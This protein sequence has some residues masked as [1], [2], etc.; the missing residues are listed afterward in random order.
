M[1]KLVILQ[2]DGDFS[3]GYKVTLE[4]GD[5]GERPD[6]RKRGELPPAL[7]VVRS[8]QEWR[9][10]YGSKH[11]QSRIKV[12]AV[13]NFQTVEYKQQCEEYSEKLLSLFHTWL[14][15]ESFN[16]ISN[17]LSDFNTNKEQ[18]LRIILSCDRLELRKL[19]WH[20]WNL[21]SGAEVALSAPDAARG[22]RILRENIRILII[23]GDSTGI[24]VKADEMLLQKYCRDAEI[25]TLV[26]PSRENLNSYLQDEIGWDILFFSG[27]SQTHNFTDTSEEGAVQGRIFVN[28]NDSLTMAQLRDSLQTAIQQRLQLAIFNSCDGLGIAAEL[29]SLQIPQVIVMREP[30]PDLVAQEFLKY[31]LEAF[32]N[33]R[34][35][36]NSVGY[37]RRQLAL[38]EDDFPCASW[39]PV[40]V[41]NQLEMPPTWQSLGITRSPYRGLMAFRE[42]DADNFFGREA[43]IE[44]LV[45]DVNRKPLVAV[46]GASGS[47][48]SSVVFAGLIP[49]LRRDDNRQWRIISFR[50]GKNPFESLAVALMGSCEIGENRRCQELELEV[51]LKQ[52]ISALA[53]MIADISGDGSR[54][55]LVV[56]QFEEIYT[57]C[58]KVEERQI[59]ID[60]LLNVCTGE[61][62]KQEGKQPFPLTVTVVMT[63]RADFLG[64]AMSYQPL[65]KAL[66]D[67]PPSLLV[68]MSRA[69]LE[70]A[71]IQPAARFSVELE[72]GLVNKLIDDVG[73]GEGSLPLQQFA[74]TQLWGKQRPGLLTHQAYTEI[75]GVT[76]AVAN[77]AEAVYAGLSEEQ[78]KRAQR[79]FIQLVQ[80]GEGTEDTR[81]L[82]T[83]DEVGD[84]WDLVTLLAN[85]RLLVTNRNQLVEDTVEVVHEALIR[86][87]GRLRGWMDDNREFRVWQERLKVALQQWVDSNKDDGSLLRGATLAVAEYWL[88][89]RGEE[90]S[91]PQRW[92]IEKSVE[93]RER[94]RKQKEKLRRQVIGGLAA[95]LVLALSLAGFAV[96]QWQEARIRGMNS[97]VLSIEALL[98]SKQD[99]DA[100]I[101]AVRIGKDL[102]KNPLGVPED[103]KIR[104]VVTLQK[105][106]YG[107]RELNRKPP[108]VESNDATE[109]KL[110]ELPP[111]TTIPSKPFDYTAKD[112]NSEID[113]YGFDDGKIQIVKK[114][115]QIVK[116]INRTSFRIE[117][118]KLSPNGSNFISFDKSVIIKLWSIDGKEIESFGEL[119]GH[120]YNYNTFDGW[121]T[122][123]EFPVITDVNFSPDSKMIVSSGRDGKIL[124]WN[125]ETSEPQIIKNHLPAVQSVEFSADGKTVISIDDDGL[126][127]FWSI[128]PRKQKNLEFGNDLFDFESIDFSHD[129][130]KFI[131]GASL[132]P[133]RLWDKNGKLLREFGTDNTR[134]G[135]VRFISNDNNIISGDLYGIHIWDKEGKLVR[136][137]KAFEFPTT[138][139]QIAPTMDFN[140]DAQVAIINNGSI[141]IWDQYGKLQKTIKQDKKPYDVSFSPNGKIIASID[142]QGIKLWNQDGKLLRS[143]K[144]NIDF[145]S[146]NFSP[147]GQIITTTDRRTI[148]FWSKEGK[149]LG[150]GNSPGSILSISFSPRSNV[151]SSG[152]DQGIIKFWSKEGK[153]LQTIRDNTYDSRINSLGFSPDGKN[154][155][156][157][158]ETAII[159]NLDLDDLL[160]KGCDWLHE[161]LITNP[162]VSA[163][164]RRLCDGIK[165]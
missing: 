76:Q 165:P 164:D 83:R 98:A 55:L 87:W 21:W 29:E 39:L 104:T 92:F 160:I 91:K 101:E 122:W 34:S 42:E 9:N 67:F 31:F 26:E 102:Q 59:F 90:V 46:I 156:Y 158:G 62:E 25:V 115:G 15:S 143:I 113:I 49:Q 5:D 152:D 153:E 127:Q 50:P 43:F 54:V 112:G 126:T 109:G 52:D 23:L 70:R 72:E 8:F 120:K 36:C 14:K 88:Q 163:E 61:L 11:G 56:D 22:V 37:A 94:E 10:I 135:K 60:G 105:V 97:S 124:I 44:Q 114:D 136:N 146:I 132:Y 28:K 96:W 159:L 129:G 139:R 6:V 35:L 144:D 17:Y 151:I 95:G 125:K 133:L 155:I 16:S 40:I 7:D 80:P 51:E 3:T 65:G 86:N 32:T 138:S 130:N 13:K 93:L 30:V 69:E 58:S 118:I 134:T 100:L 24:N 57:L 1:K 117:G 38:L 63:L 41:Q 162:N 161:Y 99:L 85:E 45:I 66:Q 123:E 84:Y 128:E 48:K 74:L 64:K 4:V 149:L 142:D 107:V 20:L 110:S 19:P 106:V 157:S 71:I 148:K 108:S 154:L 147:N 47:G 33:G 121:R 2:F 145:G 119:G 131:T 137:F 73:A 12:N 82:A 77:H 116:T 75:G 103:T 111:L 141:Q 150:Q 89:K 27:H 53:R 79:V 78:Q 81:R 68:P 140:S 18:E